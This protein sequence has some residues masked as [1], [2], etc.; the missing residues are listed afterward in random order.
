MQSLLF[1]NMS[2][3]GLQLGTESAEAEETTN[4]PYCLVLSLHRPSAAEQEVR[5]WGRG[6]GLQRIKLA[7]VGVRE[8]LG[9]PDFVFT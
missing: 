7:L 5:D 9:F 6:G 2:Q 8:G 3:T 1:Q 4:S